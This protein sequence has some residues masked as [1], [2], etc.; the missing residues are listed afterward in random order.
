M[1]FLKE[2]V[3]ND[4]PWHSGTIGS[5]AVSTLGRI[6]EEGLE[7]GQ[8]SYY[9]Q[10]DL[11]NP[12]KSNRSFWEAMRMLRNIEQSVKLYG[13]QGR[14]HTGVM[15]LF[16]VL[17]VTLIIADLFEYNDSM[18]GNNVLNAN[19]LLGLSNI[20]ISPFMVGLGIFGIIWVFVNDTLILHIFR[21]ILILYVFMILSSLIL[22]S[23]GIFLL[24]ENR[25]YTPPTNPPII[26]R[27][28]A[29]CSPILAGLNICVITTHVVIVAV[30]GHE[31]CRRYSYPDRGMCFRHYFCCEVVFFSEIYRNIRCYCCNRR[32]NI[33]E[34]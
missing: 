3:D 23:F 7:G 11:L 5:H 9:I 31:R 29:Y 28:V 26:L 19:A 24:A 14:V 16:Y 25:S 30:C 15:V 21:P 8:T 20:T 33:L 12:G 17:N 13:R 6:V 1:S 10:D 34:V 32:D 27:R 4:E 2:Q 22:L 18:R